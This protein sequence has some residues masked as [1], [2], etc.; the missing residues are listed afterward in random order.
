MVNH[1]L[2]YDSIYKKHIVQL[3]LTHRE[4]RIDTG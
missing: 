1:K 4:G 2:T 3:Y